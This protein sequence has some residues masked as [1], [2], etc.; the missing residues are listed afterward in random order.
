[1]KIAIVTDI[2]W[3]VR[4]NSQFFLN[5]QEDF[6]Y[7]TFIPYLLEN[8]IDT[9]WMLGD[10]FE[11]RKML[12]TQILNKVHQFLNKLEDLKINSYF[13]IGNHDAAFKNT[14][15]VNSLVPITK[16]FRRIHLIDK[17][18]TINFDGLSVG[19][20]SWISPE[21]HAEAIDWIK[22]VDAKVLCGH[23]EINS[24]EIIKGLVCSKG[25]ESEIF[26]RFDKVFSGHFHIRSTNG[27]IQYIGNPYQTNWGEY[28]YP[29]GFAIFDT[30]TKEVEFI[31]NPNSSYEII[32][33]T[34]KIELGFLDK[35]KYANKI[36]RIIVNKCEDKKKL[37]LLI[38]EIGSVSY[39]VEL[40]ENREIVVDDSNLEEV[41]SDTIQLIYQFL[42]TCK[43][44]N[45]NKT[46][47]TDL[48]MSVY[49]EA[50]EKGVN[51]C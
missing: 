10:F 21:I 48:I 18:E 47:L 7:S 40:I 28:G 2:H 19:F 50:I 42:D 26:E 29:K 16:G 3:G 41:P 24:F 22:T 8:N 25:I 5:K 14:N 34:D 45:V 17:Y 43:I 46:Q 15:S 9:I 6:F 31:D 4:N 38:N 51:E 30:K 35:E 49:S 32:H 27:I 11:N 37:E 12:S 33:Y 44:E 1:M 23:L 39:S 20:I 36:V 13:L